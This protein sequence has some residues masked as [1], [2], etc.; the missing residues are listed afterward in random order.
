MLVLL[1][2]KTD[3]ALHPLLEARPVERELV[4]AI[5]TD[6]GLCGALNTNLAREASKLD[7]AKTLFVGSGRKIVG[8]LARS[9]RT[10]LADFTLQDPATYTDTRRISS[11]CLE[12]FLSG[13]VDKVSVLYTRFVNTLTQQ[14]TLRTI[15]PIC[16]SE[17]AG[18]A[19]PE[20]HQGADYLFEPDPQAVLGA[21][22]PHWVHLAIFQVAQEA[23]ASEHSAR[24]VAMK[25]ATE[26]AKSLIKDLT[27]EYNKL[28]QTSITTEL[29]EI[30]TAQMALA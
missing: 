17:A 16:P 7:P 29:L 30:A 8:F 20:E 6:R 19:G 2:E 15:L 21:I 12:K 28:R 24:M 5:S 25:N 18:E 10:L 23:R 9:K 4:V 14:P 13:E 3:A 11:F 26:N 27:L 1:R 22:L